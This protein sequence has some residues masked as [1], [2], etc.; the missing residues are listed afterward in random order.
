MFVQKTVRFCEKNRFVLPAKFVQVGLEVGISIDP[1]SDDLKRM[2][3]S[4]PR[5]LFATH[6]LLNE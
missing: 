4:L 5:H 6:E 1:I 3:H 2:L